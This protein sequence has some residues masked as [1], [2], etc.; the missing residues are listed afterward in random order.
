MIWGALTVAGVAGCG[1]GGLPMA[2]VHGE[3]KFDGQPIETGSIAFHPEDGL[4]PSTG[5]E[6]KNGQYSAR[7]PP[8]TK[9]IEIR[10]SKRVG[11]RKPTPENPVE[12]PIYMELIPPIYNIQT[13]LSKQVKMPDT[14]IDL[15]LKP[16]A[17]SAMR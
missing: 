16:M 12:E 6:I 2:D 15:D 14:Q 17:D 9:K 7:V 3:V 13:T 1:R 4:G 8:G 10:G 5:G 11:T